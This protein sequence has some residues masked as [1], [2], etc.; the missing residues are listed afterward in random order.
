MRNIKPIYVM[1]EEGV[2][3][4]QQHAVLS[5]IEEV[6]N[7]ASVRQYFEM[8]NFGVWRQSPYQQGGQLLPWNSIDWYIQRGRKTSSRTGQ[9]NG[10]SMIIDL[11][12]E[13]WKEAQPHYD[14]VVLRS[15]MYSGDEKTSFVIGLA[16]EGVG[17]IISVNRFQHLNQ[18]LQTE[19]VTTE[20]MHELGHVFGIIPKNRSHS[21]SM[22]LGKHCT[23]ICVMRQGLQVPNDWIR[24]T[25]DRL[26]YG[27]YC[28]FCHEGLQG[29]FS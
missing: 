5:G 29:S 6:L 18:L 13:P 12:I 24:M 8:M 9:L 20:V 10:N 27:P 16:S 19:C 3:D 11:T 25:K 22:S 26:R 23:E 15:D 2:E 4:F 28:R 1:F 14:V 7:L 21:V 17:T